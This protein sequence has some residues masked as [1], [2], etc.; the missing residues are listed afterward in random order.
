MSSDEAFAGKLKEF[1]RNDNE[2]LFCYVLRFCKHKNISE[3]EI[4]NRLFSEGKECYKE[5]SD[6]DAYDLFS[7]IF[8]HSGG[9]IVCDI[10]YEFLEI[11][12]CECDNI[13]EAQRN[14]DE[15]ITFFVKYYNGCESLSGA[16]EK[17]IS[18]IEK[19]EKIKNE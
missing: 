2:T 4:F 7:E 14:S 17:S 9:V 5:K 19:K 11:K 10:I 13:Y 16:I 1:K 3:N 15:T 6:E 12:D 18:R 8:Y